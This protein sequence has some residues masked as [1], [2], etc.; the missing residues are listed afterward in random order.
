MNFKKKIKKTIF[1]LGYKSG[2]F[3]ALANLG[4]ENFLTVLNYHRVDYPENRP[5]L[6]PSLISAIPEDFEAQMR[7]LSQDYSPVSIKDVLGAISGKKVLPKKAVLVTVDD[8]YR[9]FDENIFPIATKYG[10]K[11]LLFVPTSYPN[12]GEFWWDKL[13]W[14]VRSWEGDSLDTPYGLFSLA[15]DA[16]R[17]IALKLLRIAIKS[18]DFKEGMRLVDS[19]DKESKP[20]VKS[21]ASDILS[22]DELRALSDKGADIAAHTHNHPLLT[23]IPFEEACAEINQ[24]LDVIRKELSQ[25]LP[26]FA[27]PDGQP[28]FFSEKLVEFLKEEGVQFA[29]TTVDENAALKEN[30]KLFF[31]R[32]GVYRSLRLP[33]FSY[34]LSPFYKKL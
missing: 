8:G 6:D 5:W 13:Y 25:D 17:E 28:D 29:V 34:R 23:K 1:Q 11:P 33:A 10:I 14:A 20:K 31:P 24:S 32:V 4:G 30:N 19:L 15:T 18:G 22:W 2:L 26:V 16:D 12:G 27:F 21:D 7:F 9:D 3:S